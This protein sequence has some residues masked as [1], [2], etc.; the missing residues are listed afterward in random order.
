MDVDEVS[1]MSLSTHV[2]IISSAAV[3]KDVFA[4]VRESLGIPQ[5]H[6]T[7]PPPFGGQDVLWSKPGGFDAMVIVKGRGALTAGD[8]EEA[9]EEGWDPGPPAWTVS[10]N[11]DTGYGYEGKYGGC[12]DV[13]NH[14]ISELM[15][16]MP[17]LD[18]WAR[19]EFD[20]TWHH[21]KIPYA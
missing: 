18:F 11:L 17:G 16:Q 6:P 20:F 10:I 8:L 14:V 4:V 7:I 19:N 1:H 2:R 5:D 15:S 9:E 21:N 3:P 12:C 13:H